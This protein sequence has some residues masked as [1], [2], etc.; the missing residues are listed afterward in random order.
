MMTKPITPLVSAPM[1]SFLTN[2]PAFRNGIK[3]LAGCSLALM[4][5]QTSHLFNGYWILITVVI[6][7]NANP[8]I[9]WHKSLARVCGTVAGAASGVAILAISAQEPVILVA[10]IMLCMLISGY[11]SCGNEYPYAFLIYGLSAMLVISLGL[12]SVTNVFPVAFF[13][14]FDIILGIL[15]Y[16][17]V[18]MALWPKPYRK[19]I[20]RSLAQCVESLRGICSGIADKVRGQAPST[21]ADAIN[22]YAQGTRQ[23][24]DDNLA[25]LGELQK[26]PFL[27][28]STLD[29]YT[30][31]AV[32]IKDALFKLDFLLELL[33]TDAHA[34]ATQEVSD[35]LDHCAGSVMRR[36]DALAILLRQCHTRQPVSGGDIPP[37]PE[38]DHD[39]YRALYSKLRNRRLANPTYVADD[40]PVIETLRIFESVEES[41]HQAAHSLHGFH[42]TQT[43]PGLHPRPLSVMG[44]YIRSSLRS[45]NPYGVRHGIKLGLAMLASIYITFATQWQGSLAMMFT[46]L[47]VMQPNLGSGLKM[48]AQRTMGSLLGIGYGLLL[49]IVVFPA[50]QSLGSL[51]LWTAPA[52]FMIGWGVTAQ[53]GRMAL[54]M[55]IGISFAFA[56]LA[57]FAPPVDLS[58]FADWGLGVIAGC[59]LA[60]TINYLIWPVQARSILLDKLRGLVADSHRIASTLFQTGSFPHEDDEAVAE[61]I[62]RMRTL[63][64]ATA[65]DASKLIADAETE[66][67]GASLNGKNIALLIAHLRALPIHITVAGSLWR[68]CAGLSLARESLAGE[69]ASYFQALDM[70]LR[71]LEKSLPTGHISAPDSGLSGAI[72]VIADKIF[73]LKQ[74]RAAL[75]DDPS[76]FAKFVLLRQTLHSINILLNRIDETGPI[77]CAPNPAHHVLRKALAG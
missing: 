18:N 36:L 28:D 24:L 33:R 68:K 7:T 50:A 66:L 35:G 52:F 29:H 69:F 8:E 13:R 56:T 75:I 2:T 73:I 14:S 77:I 67:T 39:S 23:L 11:G 34:A 19:D 4:L 72:K 46:T 71:C 5:A 49:A 58:R 30:R 20:P 61:R 25:L 22:S 38:V 9:S 40:L 54:Y 3:T 63:A 45:P 41:L 74:Q 65:A 32:A 55:Q 27:H 6:L 37:I 16:W 26:N 12:A 1:D 64:Q 47:I 43:R 62:R 44:E 31:A 76:D 42:I 51:L 70:R 17:I 21:P 48:M 10:G 60:G 15:I 53:P 57:D 59:L